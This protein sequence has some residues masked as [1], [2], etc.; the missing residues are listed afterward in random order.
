LQVTQ[1]FREI[2]E[3]HQSL[4]FSVAYRILGDAGTAEEVAQ[5]VFLELHRSL[6][7][8]ESDQHVLFWLRRVTVH[9]STDALRRRR[10]RP[11]FAAADLAAV[12]QDGDFLAAC[13]GD[14]GT[15]SAAGL[16]SRVERLMATLTPVQRGAMVLRYQEDLSPEEIAATMEIPVATVKSHLQRALQLL[17]SKAQR[18]L[19]E[20]T[21]G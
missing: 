1:D 15:S 16:A 4:V 7:R 8:L 13:N 17:R 19:K 2:V 20:Y 3:T 10:V 6:H 12:E 18:S 21:R 11:E 9:R 5:D 14:A